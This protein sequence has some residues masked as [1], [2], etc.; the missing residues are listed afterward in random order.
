MSQTLDN[1]EVTSEDWV[2][3]STESGI[4]VGTAYEIS[5]QLGGVVLLYEAN[6]KPD[7]TQKSGQRLPSFPAEN[8]NAQIT[9][10]S[11][12]IWAIALQNS[13]SLNLQEI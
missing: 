1:I 11:L 3:L 10:G 13:A 7:V 8:N 5:N 12:K 9:A 2:D 6:T 4:A